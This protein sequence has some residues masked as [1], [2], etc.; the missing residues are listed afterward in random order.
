MLLP[1]NLY[2]PLFGQPTDVTEGFDGRLDD[3]KISQGY[4][5]DFIGGLC[6]GDRRSII[7]VTVEH[8]IWVASSPR[9]LA[10]R[11]EVLLSRVPRSPGADDC[12]AHPGTQASDRIPPALLYWPKEG[13]DAMLPEMTNVNADMFGWMA[14]RPRWLL[15]LGRTM[16]CSLGS[17]GSPTER[18]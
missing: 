5:G 16:G 18:A 6:Q 17:A 12:G 9:L 8:G 4:T 1:L 7:H 3:T 2:L 11:C 14:G 15:A 10:T 13:R